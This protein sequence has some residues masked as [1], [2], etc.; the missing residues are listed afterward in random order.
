MLASEIA[1]LPFTSDIFL[2][3][4]WSWNM[5]YIFICPPIC[6]SVYPSIHLSTSLSVC[7]SACTSVHLPVHPSICLSIHLSIHPSILPSICLFLSVFLKISFHG[8]WRTGLAVIEYRKCFLLLCHRLPILSPPYS[9]WNIQVISHT[10]DTTIFHWKCHICG[11]PY[12]AK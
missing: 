1:P 4:F 6:P 9:V 12:F 3:H 2:S 10:S 8:S 5:P 7:P 11:I